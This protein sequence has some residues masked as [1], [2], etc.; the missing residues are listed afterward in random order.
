VLL[1]GIGEFVRWAD[2][3][4]RCVFLRL[5]PIPRTRAR[6]EDEFRRAF[7]ADRPGILGAVLDAMVGGRRELPSVHLAELPRMADYAMWGEAVG[8]GLGWEPGTFLSTYTDNRKEA[9]L[10][11]LLGSPLGNA[12]LQVAS[13]IPEVSETPGKLHANLTEIV[14]KKVAASADWPKTA[15]SF[16]DALRRLAPQIR[17]H[18]VSISFER[19]HEGRM[20]ILKSER[21]A[22][23]SAGDARAKTESS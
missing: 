11:D 1:S 13:L 10:T 17:L 3:K 2:L 7:H 8:R 19:R 6:G 5:P 14:G 16:G 12:L 23:D 18:G 22:I 15:G 20:I 9:T 4:D 21:V